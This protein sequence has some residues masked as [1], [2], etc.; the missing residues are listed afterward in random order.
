MTIL[1][2]VD[3][4]QACDPAEL[5]REDGIKLRV[6]GQATPRDSSGCP[7]IEVEGA[8]RAAVLD[9]I[10]RHWNRDGMGRAI[11][12]EWF[13]RWVVRRVMSRVVVD[14]QEVTVEDYAD[15]LD[16]LLDWH[17]AAEPE[18]YR[19]VGSWSE[20]HNVCDANEFV[21]DADRET[22]IKDPFRTAGTV[23]HT[24]DQAALDAYFTFVN[25][26]IAEVERRRGWGS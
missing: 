13:D 26:A 2:W 9:Y 5:P 22:G 7:D 20:L 23:D 17:F 19:D 4:I 3:G 24:V 1:Y 16:D 25:A 11:D 15:V 18:R 12:P 10:D 6:C 14:D 8:D 21:I